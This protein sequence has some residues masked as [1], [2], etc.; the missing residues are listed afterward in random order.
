MTPTGEIRAQHV[1]D[2]L[3]SA[4]VLGLVAFFPHVRKLVIRCQAR[5]CRGGAEYARRF[6]FGQLVQSKILHA[7]RLGNFNTTKRAAGPRAIRVVLGQS[8]QLVIRPQLHESGQLDLRQGARASR[9]SHVVGVRANFFAEPQTSGVSC[10][11]WKKVWELC[12]YLSLVW[13]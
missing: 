2:R 11:W 3:G 4:R 10:W 12:H 6:P 7:H 8:G 9:I 13:A 5:A 1:R